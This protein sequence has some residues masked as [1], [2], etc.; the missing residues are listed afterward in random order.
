[1]TLPTKIK[2]RNRYWRIKRARKIVGNGG[3]LCDGLCV[4]GGPNRIR[5]IYLRKGLSE[6][7]LVVI[8]MHELIHA[9]IW[10]YGIA[11][12]ITSGKPQTKKQ[13]EKIEEDICDSVS[14]EFSKLF[15]ITL[16]F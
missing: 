15:N 9:I 13:L 2:I 5:D 10:E 4:F 3:V 12:K 6:Q 14:E 7:R 16:N 8:F 1:M 11:K